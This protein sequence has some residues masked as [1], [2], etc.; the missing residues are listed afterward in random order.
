MSEIER[1]FA[2]EYPEFYAIWIQLT[3]QEQAEVLEEAKR[4]R[5][6]RA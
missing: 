5:E 4:I 2:E 6:G 3:E 1:K